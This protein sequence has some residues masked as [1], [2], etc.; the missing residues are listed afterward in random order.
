V[1]RSLR[2]DARK[3]SGELSKETGIRQEEI[4]R[5][6]IRLIERKKPF[7]FAATDYARIDNWA[8]IHVKVTFQRKLSQEDMTELDAAGIAPPHHDWKRIEEGILTLEPRSFRELIDKTNK[9]FS[10]GMR[11]RSLSVEERCLSSQPWLDK[12]LSSYTGYTK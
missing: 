3:S 6:I 4:E 1:P 8:H 7:F 9:I 10:A 2:K 11:I 5:R 12:L